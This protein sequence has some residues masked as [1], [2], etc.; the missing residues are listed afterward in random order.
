M[1]IFMLIINKY[2]RT[3]GNGIILLYIIDL[4]KWTGFIY[5][6]IRSKSPFYR[7]CTNLI[8]KSYIYIYI[9]LA[10]YIIYLNFYWTYLFSMSDIADNRLNLPLSSNSVSDNFKAWKIRT[11]NMIIVVLFQKIALRKE[12]GS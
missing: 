6:I 3:W 4:N 5:L 9:I 1:R 12:R 7:L 11:K 2:I 10:W 8:L